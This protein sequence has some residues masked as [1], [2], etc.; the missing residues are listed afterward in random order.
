[1]ILD[2]RQRSFEYDETLELQRTSSRYLPAIIP[3]NEVQRT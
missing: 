1:M 2:T 3:L